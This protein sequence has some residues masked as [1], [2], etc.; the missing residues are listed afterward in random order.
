MR[1]RCFALARRDCARSRSRSSAVAA[2]QPSSLPRRIRIP[3]D[4]LAGFRAA[5]NVAR[6]DSGGGRH[7][8]KTYSPSGFSPWQHPSLSLQ[9]GH[10]RLECRHSI[11]ASQRGHSVGFASCPVMLSKLATTSDITWKTR[12]A[13]ACPPVP[14]L[15]TSHREARNKRHVVVPRRRTC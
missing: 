1:A 13:T 9:R 14:V 10:C 4:A 3:N 8:H 11:L 2:C 7:N 15:D 5:D 12:H 6:P